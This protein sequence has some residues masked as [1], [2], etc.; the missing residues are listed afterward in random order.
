MLWRKSVL[1]SWAK[2]CVLTA[3]QVTSLDDLFR[4]NNDWVRGW[5]N[6]ANRHSICAEILKYMCW[7]TKIAVNI[8]IFCC[9]FVVFQV[10]QK[11]NLFLEEKL[12]FE[13]H[14][15]CG[16]CQG[17]LW[18][19]L[20]FYLFYMPGVFIF[21]FCFPCWVS[22][23]TY[24]NEKKYAFLFLYVFHLTWGKSIILIGSCNQKLNENLCAVV[25][26]TRWSHEL[27]AK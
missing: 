5:K 10:K 24:K 12:R 1:C 8:H 20:V 15:S 23:V 2:K 16:I 14:V 3:R 4:P 7:T 19:L 25:L 13:I 6:W 18:I 21:C 17:K 11:N 22:L 27:S 26:N 9:L